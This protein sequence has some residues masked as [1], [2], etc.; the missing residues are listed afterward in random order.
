MNDTPSD[1]F[2]EEFTPPERLK[3]SAAALQWAR[4]YFDHLRSNQAG[5]W[6]VVFDWASSMSVRRAPDVPSEDL[7]ACLVL[8]AYRR[9][10]IPS[11]FIAR[12]DGLEFAIKIPH[13]IWE[14]LPQRLIDLDNTKHFRLGLR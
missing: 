10:E 7:G 13:Q 12:Q 8:G 9:H 1:M 6:V 5:D 4:E 14:N 3:I 11:G 2:E